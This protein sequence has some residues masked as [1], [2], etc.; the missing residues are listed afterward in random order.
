MTKPSY[1]LQKISEI[2]H[3]KRHFSKKYKK[4]FIYLFI[5][6]F[7]FVKEKRE[8]ILQSFWEHFIFNMESSILVIYLFI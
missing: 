2:S 3:P 7:I 8:N 6:I 1:Y 4:I 5:F